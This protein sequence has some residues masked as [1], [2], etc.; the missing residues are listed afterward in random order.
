MADDAKSESEEEYYKVKCPV[1]YCGK[2]AY[3]P[4]HDACIEWLDNHLATSTLPTH[5]IYHGEDGSDGAEKRQEVLLEILEDKVPP[6]QVREWKEWEAK[7]E[8][9][10]ATSAA[11][12][13]HRGRSRTRRRGE[14][15]DEPRGAP[16]RDDSRRGDGR[17]DDGRRHD[18]HRGGPRRAPSTPQR[19]GAPPPPPASPPRAGGPSPPRAGGPSPQELQETVQKTAEMLQQTVRS[20]SSIVQAATVQ[21]KA[22]GAAPVAPSSAAQL[23]LVMAPMAG[24][25][26]TSSVTISAASCKAAAATTTTSREAM[27]IADGGKGA[28]THARHDDDAGDEDGDG[29][30]D[31][32]ND[33]DEAT[34]A[35]TVQGGARLHQAGGV[36]CDH[37]GGRVRQSGRRF[38]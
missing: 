30:G 19:R 37:G 14:P 27:V 5:S 24:E 28:T 36:M 21:S 23:S 38:P 16:S 8:K 1:Q 25:A 9:E 26:A 13:R 33:D 2:L 22:S 3:K 34:M 10:Q 31:A 12:P 11:R 4:S 20:V 17:R 6:E 35:A 18:S 32:D 29:D 7:K 15:R